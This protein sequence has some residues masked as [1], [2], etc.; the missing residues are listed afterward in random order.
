MNAFL[1]PT[2]LGIACF[3]LPGVA[4][5]Q[6]SDATVVGAAVRIRT[7]IVI[8]VIASNLLLDFGHLKGDEAA[9]DGTVTVTPDSPSVRTTTGGATL[10]G[11]KLVDDNFGPAEF[12]VSGEPLAPYTITFILP[13]ATSDKGTPSLNV[14]NLA[15]LTINDMVEDIGTLDST[16]FDRVRVGGTLDVPA[17][18]R[19]GKY[20][21]E[22][23]LMFN[24]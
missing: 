13:T 23:E 19:P 24:Y 5:A 11:A 2:I 1:R 10:L 18:A 12:T 7:P 3:A 22:I 16:G 8:N 20:V 15:P 4:V 14:I 9:L 6:S 21:A 17:R